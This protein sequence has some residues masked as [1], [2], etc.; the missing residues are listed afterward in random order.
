MIQRIYPMDHPTLGPFEVFLVPVGS[1]EHGMLSE[2]VFNQGDH[3]RKKVD[4]EVVLL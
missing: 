3:S 1:D 2:L 4:A